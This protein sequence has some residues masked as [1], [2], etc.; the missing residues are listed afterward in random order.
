[1]TSVDRSFKRRHT[2]KGEHRPQDLIAYR[3]NVVANT[4]FRGAGRYYWRKYAL[5]LPEVRVLAIVGHY[6]PMSSQQV[7]ARCSMDK[8]Q[9]SR[10][11]TAL[12]RRGAIRRDPDPHDSRRVVLSLTDFG[13]TLWDAVTADGRARHEALLA[14]FDMSERET[15]YRLLERLLVYSEERHEMEDGSEI[16]PFDPATAAS[17]SSA[18]GEDEGTREE[19][20]VDDGGATP[21]ARSGSL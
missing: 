7:S 15:L 6:A 8:A 10:A 4:L 18:E 13:Q 12:I 11:V 19:N 20:E 3:I 21:P 9:V 2:A 16:T 1:M 14:R 17:A 5:R